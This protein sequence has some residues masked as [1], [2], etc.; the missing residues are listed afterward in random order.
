MLYKKLYLGDHYP[1]LKEMGSVAT[2]E[3]YVQEDTVQKGNSSPKRGM[4]ICPGSAYL[5][6]ARIET[7]GVAMKLLAMDF[8]V[9]V[10]TYSCS[11]LHYPL[12]ILE[13]A[14]LYDLLDKNSQEWNIDIEKTGIL[15]FSAGGHLAAHYSNQYQCEEIKAHFNTVHKPWMSVLCYSVLSADPNIRH[16]GSFEHLLGHTPTAEEVERFSCENMVSADTPK[17]FMWHT[18]GDQ[19][20]PVQNSLRYAEALSNNGIAY[21]LHVYPYGRH[22]LS[23][24]DKMT[25]ETVDEKAAYA[26]DWLSQF[27]KW[28]ALQD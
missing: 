13:V 28:L 18:V 9:F 20:V 15:G 14:A 7:E 26:H 2:V 1:F 6:C 8:N 12:Q 27:E 4:V 22:G 17:T 11:P 10:I 24:V 3:V 5:H 21:T 25:Q 16:Q 19:S 23:T